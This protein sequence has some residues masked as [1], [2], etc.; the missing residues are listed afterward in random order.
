M[1]FRHYFFSSEQFFR[2]QFFWVSKKES[3]KI[4]LNVKTYYLYAIHLQTNKGGETIHKQKHIRI[5]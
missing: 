5:H 4:L 3:F 1:F 2:Q